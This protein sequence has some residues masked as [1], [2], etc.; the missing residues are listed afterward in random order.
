M[1]ALSTGE[2]IDTVNGVVRWMDALR[3]DILMDALSSGD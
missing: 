1:D 3:R 2:W